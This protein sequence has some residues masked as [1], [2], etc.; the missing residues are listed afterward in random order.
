MYVFWTNGLTHMHNKK[1]SMWKTGY[2]QSYGLEGIAFIQWVFIDHE[3]EDSIMLSTSGEVNSEGAQHQ[4]QC[5]K[6]L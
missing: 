6:C 1:V 2:F 4:T 5:D 3:C